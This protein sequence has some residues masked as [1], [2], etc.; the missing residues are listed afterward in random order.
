MVNSNNSSVC[1]FSKDRQRFGNNIYSHFSYF[2]YFGRPRVS[3][4]YL[5]YFRESDIVLNSQIT[6]QMNFPLEFLCNF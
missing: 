3:L 1:D 4:V 2:V 6:Y 5:Y